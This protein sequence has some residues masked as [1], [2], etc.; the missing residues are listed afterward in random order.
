MTDDQTKRFLEFA[1]ELKELVKKYGIGYVK[2]YEPY[3]DDAEPYYH[4]TIDNAKTH[5]SINDLVPE[6]Y[7]SQLKKP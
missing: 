1:A 4:F 7:H 5:L 2:L 6:K 3:G